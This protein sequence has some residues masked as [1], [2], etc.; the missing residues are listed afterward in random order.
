MVEILAVGVVVDHGAAEFE[1]CHAALQL[2]GRGLGVLH[3][4]VREAGK[5]IGPLLDL[6]GEEVVGRLGVVLHALQNPDGTLG[7]CHAGHTLQIP[8]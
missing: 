1:L 6:L 5:A 7:E 3:G 4:E 2:V 8:V